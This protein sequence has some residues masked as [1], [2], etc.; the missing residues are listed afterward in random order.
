M[1]TRILSILI[2]LLIG[3]Y[4]A[5]W[6]MQAYYIENT[7]KQEIA[8]AHPDAEITYDSVE[9]SGFP[10][11]IQISLVNPKVHVENKALSFD[12]E[13]K[14]ATSWSL[15][16]RLK[17]I[18]IAGKSHIFVPV[19][20][21]AT[22]SMYHFEGNTVLDIDSIQ[23][24]GDKGKIRITN[25]KALSL[26]S[27]IHGPFEWLADL[28]TCDYNVLSESH[29]RSVVD[30][31][32]EVRGAEARVLPTGENSFLQELYK[33]FFGTIAEKSGKST[34]SFVVKCDMPSA[35]KVQ[36]L[37][38]SPLQLFTKGVPPVTI[39]L[40]RFDSA[41][42]LT[43]DQMTARI[44]LGEDEH[45]TV[46]LQMTGDGS[47]RYFE[48]YREA[49]LAAVDNVTKHV[50]DWQA[51]EDLVELKNFLISNASQI[52]ELVPHL[53]RY[54]NIEFFD[55]M[56]VEINKLTFNWHL[57]IK[58][59]GIMCDLY[60]IDIKAD[61]Q[62]RNSDLQVEATIA[63]KNAQGL[64][65]DLTGFYNKAINIANYFEKDAEKQFRVLP[66]SAPQKIVTF[67]KHLS[68]EHDDPKG[69]LKIVYSYKEGKTMIGALTLEEARAEAE[70]LWTEVM[71]GILPSQPQE[72]GKGTKGT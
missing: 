58:R 55:D 18:E 66:A 3:G 51:P 30:L 57:G 53:E 46:V 22:R 64:V 49:L 13:G 33:A 62:N 63:L 65:D 12:V 14:F 59:L 60:G 19:K 5:F 11:A 16:A 48:G 47:V 6:Y 39:E 17:A 34:A 4:T 52:K 29:D 32:V 36:E 45:N 7:L 56:F 61:A 9:K 8:K 2:V 27:D 67:L 71:T 43:K 41:N 1:K 24:L 26:G 15:F 42:V 68:Q 38:E 31:D 28:V 70:A 23:T 35:A 44:H 72:E 21:G 10:F 20:E 25:A 37:T 40:K 69:V 54:G 50:P